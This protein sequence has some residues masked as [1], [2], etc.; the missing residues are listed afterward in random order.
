MFVLITAVL[1]YLKNYLFIWLLWPTGFSLAVELQLEL[2]HGM[3]D[4]SF[5]I[6]G[7]THIPCPGSRFLTTGPL[8]GKFPRKTHTFLKHREIMH[9]L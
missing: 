3:W 9:K 6:R 2:P 8:S 7:G 5:S 1:Y 4:I